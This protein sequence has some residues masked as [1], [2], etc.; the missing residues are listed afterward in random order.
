MDMKQQGIRVWDL[1]TRAFHWTLAVTVLVAVVSGQVGGNW[2]D[3]HARCGLLAVG[4]VVFRLV[5]G[6]VGSTYARF[7][8]FF[9]PPARI[10]AYLAGDWQGEG[11]NPLGAASV[12]ALLGLLT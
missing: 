8:Q 3:W 7:A 6:V 5:W 1:P 12:F 2:I 10:R 11:H 9:P 4:L